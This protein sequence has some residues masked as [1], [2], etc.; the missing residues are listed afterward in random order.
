MRNNGWRSLTVKERIQASKYIDA[1]PETT[2]EQRRSKTILRMFV[3]DN[4]SASAISRAK[5]P[6]IIA[7]GNR[8][9][10]KPLSTTSVLEVIYQHFPEW[11]GRQSHKRNPRVDLI[12]RRQRTASPHVR[13]CAF[14]GSEDNLEEHH[15]IPLFMGG[16]NDDR[17]LVF[18]CHD[19][20]AQ[21]SAYQQ[22]I[23]RSDDV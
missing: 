11:R 4:M 21:V 17:N 10:G 23:R 19:C 12:I 1:L 22:Y 5:H 15:M 8:A 20:H 18:L 13:R 6:D 2:Q 14:C 16:T 9:C 7:L 3:D